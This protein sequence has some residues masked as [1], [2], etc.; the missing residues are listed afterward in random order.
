[1]CCF[2]I[3]IPCAQGSSFI[4]CVKPNLKMVSHQFEGALILSQLQCSGEMRTPLTPVQ[5]TWQSWKWVYMCMSLVRD[6][7]SFRPDAGGLP[8]QGSFPWAVQHVQTVHAWQA[9]T[10]QSKTLLQGAVIVHAAPTWIHEA[11]FHSL[12]VCMFD[13][14]KALFKALG[15][16]D[17][18]FKFGLTR[19]FFRPGKVKNKKVLIRKSL[20]APRTNIFAFSCYSLPSLT[21]SWSLT[22]TTSQSCW[23]K[24]TLGWC[25][26]AGRKSSGAACLS[27]NVGAAPRAQPPGSSWCIT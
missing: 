6:G 9:D 7:V 26:A 5:P 3:T 24:S 10:P 11:S 25:T 27:S 12:K 22:Q 19:V 4:R 13:P 15:L 14:L 20:N 16:N 8:L 1:M 2:E 23:R 17:N 18:D 21:R